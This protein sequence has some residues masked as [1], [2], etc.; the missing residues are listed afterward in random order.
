MKMNLFVVIALVLVST[1]FASGTYTFELNPQTAS[2]FVYGLGQASGY[3]NQCTAQSCTDNVNNGQY[4]AIIV[5]EQYYTQTQFFDVND[6]NAS[7][8]VELEQMPASITVNTVPSGAQ[9]K[10][11]GMDELSGFQQISTSPASFEQLEAGKYIVRISMEGYENYVKIVQAYAGQNTL[12]EHELI[13]IAQ[14]QNQSGQIGV[15]T[16][17]SAATVQIY[18]TQEL[19]GLYINS[20]TPYVN[21][22]LTAGK[23]LVRLSLEGYENFAQTYQINPGQ[24]TIVN[25]TLVALPPVQTGN[26]NIDTYPTGANLVIY[27]QGQTLNGIAPYS[28]QNATTGLRMVKATLA[29]FKLTSKLFLVS[30]AY[31]TNVL[32]NMTPN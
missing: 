23:Y 1:I 9:V 6:N 8:N 28:Y 10:I 32:V 2:V 31:T 18:G 24:I 17:P 11:N 14:P 26:F 30:P 15:F 20:T 16:T 27:G 13:P 21:A 4:L 22:N 5:N 7:F 29:G 3:Y 12:V 25:R 19:S